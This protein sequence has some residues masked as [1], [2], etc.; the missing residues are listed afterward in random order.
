VA[1]YGPVIATGSV[2]GTNFVYTKWRWSDMLTSMFHLTAG[3][4]APVQVDMGNGVLAL[5][6]DAGA[7]PADASF[8]IQSTHKLAVT[9]SISGQGN[10]YFEPHAHVAATTLAGGTN[11]TFRLQLYVAS[12]NGSFATTYYQRTNTLGFSATNQ[13]NI[14]S[15]GSITNNDLSGKSSVV[16]RGRMVR[17]T[18]TAQD[19]GAGAVVVLDSFDIHYPFDQI[20]SANRSGD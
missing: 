5:G 11:V 4:T 14:L 3:S 7:T 2:E 10:F 8:S 15:F 12:V 9:N 20:G 16:F 17:Q 18:S 1:V 19:I 13:N 6:Y